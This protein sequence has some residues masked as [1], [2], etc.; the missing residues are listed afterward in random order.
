MEYPQVPSAS[1]K[2]I[3]QAG[4]TLISD[5]ST[6]GGVENARQLLVKWRACHFLPMHEFAE[7]LRERIARLGVEGM[8]A[9]RLKRLFRIRDKLASF[10]R[11]NVTTMQDIG[12]V[13]AVV[14]TLAEVNALV[15]D[16][17][18]NP[19]P[20]G[21]GSVEQN[22]IVYPKDNGYRSVHYVFK[23][24]DPSGVSPYDGLRIEIQLRTQKQHLWASAVEI[25]GLISGS[26]LKYDEGDPSTMDFF[27]LAAEMVACS[28]GAPRSGELASLSPADLRKLLVDAES[29]ASAL[30]TLQ[31]APVVCKTPD[32]D[33]HWGD[34][35]DNETWMLDLDL[36]RRIIA[37]IR[38]PSGETLEAMQRY[39]E[40]EQRQ[41]F[42]EGHS[43]VVLVSVTSAKMLM[44][45]YPT[46]FL[47]AT[48]FIEM[49]EEYL[50]G[51]GL[52]SKPIE[53]GAGR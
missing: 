8:V 23:Y 20:M 28:E 43:S 9:M 12:A 11:M 13:R 45:A 34:P 15:E 25:A 42:D 5:T 2:A 17:A 21:E 24:K 4:D 1:R 29:D 31:A 14:A 50:R 37:A 7:D 30:R 38:Y 27:R 19:P 10:P 47:D 36:E 48:E 35:G 16:Y 32:F 44:K 51:G 53:D 46:F 41:T 3:R 6:I 22:Y 26:R 39:A 33:T 49:I 18:A 40:A 52:D